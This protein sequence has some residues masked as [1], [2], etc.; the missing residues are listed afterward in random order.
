MNAIWDKTELLR[1]YRKHNIRVVVIGITDQF[2]KSSLDCIALNG[3][4]FEIE[5]FESEHFESIESDL[6]RILCPCS[7]DS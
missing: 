2:L 4:I 7:T 3:D 6:R 5:G 1:N